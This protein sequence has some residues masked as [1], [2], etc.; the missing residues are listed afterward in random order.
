M[1][2]GRSGHGGYRDR[3]YEQLSK[4][5]RAHFEERAEAINA[6]L[7]EGIDPVRPEQLL[8]LGR[9]IADAEVDEILVDGDDSSDAV[10]VSMRQGDH[11]DRLRVVREGSAWKV[12]IFGP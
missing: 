5:S 12:D 6:K 7:P 10:V 3:A 8:E 9:L 1:Q 4:A 2:Y 11:T